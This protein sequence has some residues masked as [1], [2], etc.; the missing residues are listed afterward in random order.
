MTPYY[1]NPSTVQPT[2]FKAIKVTG[3]RKY[4]GTGF[5]IATV[6]SSGCM[7]WKHTGSGWVHNYYETETAKIWVPSLKKFQYANMKYVEE[8]PSVSAAECECQFK[9]YAANQ[10]EQTLAWCKTQRPQASAT[11]IAQ[12]A[13]NVLLKHHPEISVELDVLL[14]DTRDVKAEIDKTLVWVKSL[15]SE[16][17]MKNEQL[18]QIATKAM[19]TRKIDQMPG[20]QEALQA[21]LTEANFL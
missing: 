11:E 7:G 9:E 13:R 5:I 17:R 3:G 6:S 20:Y 19:H 12:F 8:D 16:R 18:V 1:T 2:S 10:V 21:A 15:T 4:Q 14:P